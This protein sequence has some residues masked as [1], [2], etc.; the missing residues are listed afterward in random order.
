MHFSEGLLEAKPERGRVMLIV[1]ARFGLGR[2]FLD[3]DGIGDD[4]GTSPSESFIRRGR[5]LPH[6]SFIHHSLC[7]DARN[8]RAAQIDLD[9]VVE[10][11]RE[12]PRKS[13]GDI[14]DGL[15]S[16]VGSGQVDDVEAAAT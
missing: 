9:L 4:V 11:A 14:T 6:R 3:R 15:V 7:Q 1:G 13:T 2:R 8:R 12:Q 5:I 10:V 16:L